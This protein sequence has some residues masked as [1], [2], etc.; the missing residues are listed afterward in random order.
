MKEASNDIMMIRLSL[1]VFAFAVVLTLLAC[2]AHTPGELRVSSAA[3]NFGNVTVGSTQK[4]VETL[5][6]AGGPVTVSSATVDNAEFATSGISL[7]ITIPSGRTVSLIL[8]FRP[9]SPGTATGGLTLESSAINS[10]AQVPV[11]GTG[12]PGVEHSVTLSWDPSAS[13]DVIGY[14]IYRGNQ[15]GGPY[16]LVNSSPDS[17]AT[18]TDDHVSGGQT[19]YY[20]VT[21]VNSDGLES[22]YSNQASVVI[23]SP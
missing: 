3:I 19:Y 10:S 15:S 21:T 16:S 5:F 20:V 18:A 23:P 17:N 7:P 2:G 11:T 12:T 13:E 1:V 6:A 8:A 4:Q 22:A 14:N 9:Q